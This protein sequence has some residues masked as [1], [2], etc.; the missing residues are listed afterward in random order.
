MKNY[1]S[2]LKFRDSDWLWLAKFRKK[3]CLK[4]QMNPA[5]TNTN[6]KRQESFK[7]KNG[8]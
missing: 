1:K 3:I 6:M 7:N 8:N 4:L 5:N 2:S